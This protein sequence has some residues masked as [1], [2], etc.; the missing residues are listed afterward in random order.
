MV[1]LQVARVLPPIFSKNKKKR[2]EVRDGSPVIVVSCVLIANADEAVRKMKTET[3][4]I[5]PSLNLN[6]S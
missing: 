6:P 3:D 4:H 5:V 1:P 2:S